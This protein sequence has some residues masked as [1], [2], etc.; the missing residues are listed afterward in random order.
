MPSGTDGIF[1]KELTAAVRAFQSAKKLR[2]DG[3]FGP[4]TWAILDAAI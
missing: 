4:A 1:G 2:V 3:V